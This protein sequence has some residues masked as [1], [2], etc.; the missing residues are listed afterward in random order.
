MRRIAL[1][2][3]CAF[4]MQNTVQASTPE[5]QL[6]TDALVVMDNEHCI[7]EMT[8]Q[9]GKCM[10]ILDQGYV[11]WFFSQENVLV[12]YKKINADGKTIVTWVKDRYGTF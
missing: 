12:S 3:A 4:A 11:Y 8:E 2:I 10:I 9:S 6:G 1:L 7:D 5:V